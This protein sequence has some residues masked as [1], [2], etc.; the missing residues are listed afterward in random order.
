[1]TNEAGGGIIEAGSGDDMDIDT[2]G[3]SGAIPKENRAR[4][5][6]HAELY[7]EAIRKRRDDV[8]KI[9]ENIGWKESAINNIK[10]HLF[11]QQ[12]LIHGEM[13]RFDP[14]YNQ[15]VAWQRLIEGKNIKESDI[16]FLRHEY[17]ELIQMKLHGYD[18]YTAHEIANKNHNWYSLILLEEG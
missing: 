5:E 13:K 12:H 14:D 15:S 2:T 10:N 3:G 18:Y 9:A 17:V 8:P 11:Y 1:L 4:R 7:Y 16:V 6:T